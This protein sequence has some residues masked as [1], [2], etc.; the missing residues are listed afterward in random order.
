MEEPNSLLGCAVC[1]QSNRLEKSIKTTWKSSEALGKTLL[2]GRGMC[3][4]GA[5]E[6][7]P[8]VIR[9][10]K[11]DTWKNNQLSLLLRFH[12]LCLHLFCWLQ[13][14]M[15]RWDTDPSEYEEEHPPTSSALGADLQRVDSKHEQW[16][17]IRTVWECWWLK[18]SHLW[19]KVRKSFMVM[20]ES[21]E[22]ALEGLSAWL[23]ASS[24]CC[25]DGG[26]VKISSLLQR[27][28]RQLVGQCVPAL[29]LLALVLQAVNPVLQRVSLW[30]A[31]QGH[32]AWHTHTHM[33]A[34]VFG[35]S[36]PYKSNANIR[37]RRGWWGWGWWWLG[38]WGWWW[39]STDNEAR[40]KTQDQQL[41]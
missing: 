31:P 12:W 19:H 39:W 11:R 30:V 26:W 18:W 41:L 28:A 32:P 22:H 25:Q 2:R 24:L 1:R 21:S 13:T 40:I 37:I 5:D 3:S 23:Q 8:E 9:A 27:G 10:S 7:G 29:H 16:S 6:K 15:E 38:W 17:Q 35:R 4:C 33:Q 34:S 20:Q 14:S 36:V